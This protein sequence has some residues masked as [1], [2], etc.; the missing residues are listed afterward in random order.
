MRR[1]R[2]TFSHWQNWVGVFLVWIFL[3]VALFAPLLSPDNPKTPGPFMRAVGLPIGDLQ[4]YSPAQIPPLGSLPGQYDVFHALVWG[5]QNA[6]S[7]GLK[8]AL[9]SAVIGVLFGATA[10]YTGGFVNGA[11]M[12]IADA[13]LSF[14]IIAGVVLLQQLWLSV[15]ADKGAVFARGEWIVPPGGAVSPVQWLFLLMDPLTFTLILFSWMPYARLTNTMVTTLKQTGFVQAARALGASPA[16]IILHHLIPNAI[17]PAVV[18]A[19]RDVGNMVILQATF[20]FIGLPGG[21]VWG[22]MLVMGRD[23]I[24][25]PGGGIMTYWWTFMPAT[26]AFI[27]FG[28]GWN[29]MG[30]TVN[31]L[32]DPREI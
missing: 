18:L 9:A 16:R 24:I 5:S 17:A 21:S 10:A 30:D 28:M 23:W 14:P 11:M 25:G 27:L 1:L 15:M 13:F 4:P 8:V 20:T 32:L 7:F 6:L 31:E 26:L 12:R 19:A 2:R 29:L 22:Q 3:E